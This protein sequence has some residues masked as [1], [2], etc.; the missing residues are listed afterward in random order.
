[1]SS[2]ITVRRHRWAKIGC[3]REG[4]AGSSAIICFVK[5]SE[6][7]FIWRRKPSSLISRTS[8]EGLVGGRLK[9]QV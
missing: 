5:S 1:M 8:M 3:Y 9:G 4:Q 6:N 2:V 7:T